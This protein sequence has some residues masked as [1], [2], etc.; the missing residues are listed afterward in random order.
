MSSK[1]FFLQSIASNTDGIKESIYTIESKFQSMN[2]NLQCM[3]NNLQL[4]TTK[5]QCI[6]EQVE[7]SNRIIQGGFVALLV[8]GLG[9]QVSKKI[10]KYYYHEN[11]TTSTPLVTPVTP[12]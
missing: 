12:L 1:L 2:N 10:I 7:N 11:N 5:F 3:N 8:T 4:L 9:Y 6:I